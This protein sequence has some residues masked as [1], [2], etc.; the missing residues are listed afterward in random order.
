M[1]TIMPQTKL[2]RC[3]F[4]LGQVVI[5]CGAEQQVPA[6]DVQLALRRHHSRDWGEVSA[7]DWNANDESLK[8]GGRLLSSY[9]ASNGVKFWIIT[10]A[11]REATTVLLPDDY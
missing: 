5:T 7:A 11:D 10:E 6:S 9:V 8:E 2:I 4:S 3:S 1:E